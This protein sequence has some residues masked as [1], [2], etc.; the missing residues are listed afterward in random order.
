MAVPEQAVTAGAS[1]PSYGDIFGT[2]GSA[3]GTANPCLAA[4]GS[5][6]CQAGQFSLLGFF[7]WCSNIQRSCIAVSNLILVLNLADRVYM[8]VP[9]RGDIYVLVRQAI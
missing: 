3:P 2:L 1:A 8:Y 5:Y 9:M 6:G 4:P 7:S